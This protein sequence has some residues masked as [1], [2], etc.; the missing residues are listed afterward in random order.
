VLTDRRMAMMTGTA[1]LAANA[2]HAAGP[3]AGSS[4]DT[5]R[6]LLWV[7]VLIG[8][9]MIGGLLVMWVRRRIL[10][11]DTAGNDGLMESLRKLRDSGAISPQEYDATRKAMARRVAGDLAN[12]KPDPTSRAANRNP[13]TFGTDGGSNHPGNDR[14]GGLEKEGPAPSDP[15]AGPA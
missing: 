10:T 4:G 1:C 5:T 14:R 15:P 3:K 9:T 7:G 12:P 13:R 2:V 8:L 11:N 6:V